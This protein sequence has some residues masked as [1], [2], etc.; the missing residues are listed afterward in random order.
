M[1]GAEALERRNLFASPSP[2]RHAGRTARPSDRGRVVGE[3]N[4]DNDVTLA[5]LQTGLPT[6]YNRLFI[7]PTAGL[8]LNTTFPTGVGVARSADTFITVTGTGG[9]A[10]LGFTKADGTALPVFGGADPGVASGIS[11]LNGGAITLFADPVLGNRMVLGID[12]ANDKALAISSTPTAAHQREG[13]D[14]S[15]RG[16]R[17]PRHH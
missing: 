16:H 14:R 6:F 5:T 2:F 8:G 4:N 3:D 17:E 12:T 1:T 13:V 9:V 11:A 10:S 7:A 15:T